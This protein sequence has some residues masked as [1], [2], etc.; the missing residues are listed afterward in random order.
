MFMVGAFAQ[1][2]GV[3]PCPSFERCWTT[4]MSNNVPLVFDQINCRRI[5]RS[6]GNNIDF[7]FLSADIR[8]RAIR[9]QTQGYRINGQAELGAMVL[10]ALEQI[11]VL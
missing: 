5:P 1:M 3:R 7:G 2:D 9:C 6:I 11:L 8:V 10:G 4:S